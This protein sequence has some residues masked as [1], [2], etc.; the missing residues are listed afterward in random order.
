MEAPRAAAVRSRAALR[1]A[2]GHYIANGI[3]VAF[4]LL[5]ISGGVHLVLGTLAASAASVGVIVTAP[6]DLPAPRRGKLLQML[7]APLI[8]LPLLFLVQLLH[9]KPLELGLLLVPATFL[10]FVAMAWGKRGIPIAI[11]VMFS[12]IFS[13]ATPKPDDMAEAVQR[14]LYFGLGAGLYVIY[15]VL[16]N[17]ALNARYRVQVMA[18]LLLSLA[19]LMRT[20]ARQF[21]PRD[22]S[23]DIREVPA[24]L[25]GQ[26]L[27]E[28]AALADLLQAARDIVLESPR[29]PYRQRLA[30]MLM[31]VLELR[32]LLLASELDLDALKTHPGHAAALVEMRRI[33][34]ALAAD[35]AA[36]A[37]A[38]LLGRPPATVPDR[39]R[40]LT[41]IHL[42]EDPARPRSYTGPTPAMLA[43]GLASRIGH[44][45]DEV[46]RLSALAR[47]EREPDLAVVRASWQMFVSPTEWSLRPFLALWRWDAP[48]L[49][50]AIR[51]ALAIA[52]GYG[53][54]L[55]L[56]WGSHDY[57]ILLTIVVVLRGSLSQTLERRNSRV[58]GT[59]LGCVFAVALLSAHPSPLTLLAAMTLAQ[60]IAHG[61][62]VR[63]YLITAVAA[64]VLGLVQAHMLNTGMSTTFALF[65]RV[66]DTLIGAALA[67]AFCYVLPS[68]ERGQ[69]PALVAR[70][71][72]AQARHARLALGL[73]QL[74]SVG[75]S[76]ELE[77]RLAR[78]EAYDSL[79][80]LVQATQRSLSEPRA[81]RP[82]LE[83][84]EHL[85]AHSYQLLAQ[86]SAV[87][88]MLVLR[89]DRLTPA[90]IEGPLART[91][92]RIEASIGAAPT[93][94]SVMP[95]GAPATTLAGPI[96][97][98]D[99]FDNDVTPWLLRR[100][101]LA[102]G[103]AAQLRDDAARILQ[104]AAEDSPH[105]AS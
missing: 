32:D 24:S 98:P 55:A 28:Q 69:I 9:A 52:A 58:A 1:V 30:G 94:G 82:P 53:I 19:A 37:D 80:A 20:E 83:P 33:L 73:G 105:T 60:A 81:V 39:R 102:T 79:S 31:T 61:F 90:E 6:P 84:L 72:G 25:L 36:L 10:A 44:I 65:E 87:K 49:R 8:G 57:W 4:G 63:R 101:D 71:L 96:P 14:T 34:E 88:S 41:A 89:R 16:A 22:D 21:T 15:A 93:S 11:A 70:V 64:T 35:T 27:R 97:L 43:R 18:D 56:P 40:E 76:P 62:A 17:L 42:D 91:A 13:M 50:H 86:L 54:A 26:L 12:M 95:E 78:R 68:W 38:L 59:L 99:P 7:P 47:G 45:N 2:L 66:A 67:W 104:P 85:Q 103:I 75:V 74:R 51:A 3:S 92:Q 77:W 46:L 48:P 29:T 100:L 5:L 23:G